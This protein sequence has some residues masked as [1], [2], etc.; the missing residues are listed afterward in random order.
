MSRRGGVERVDFRKPGPG[1]GEPPDADCVKPGGKGKVNDEPPAFRCATAESSSTAALAYISAWVCIGSGGASGSRF[2][3][4]GPYW[5]MNATT[6]R[7][8]PIRVYA[9]PRMASFCAFVYSV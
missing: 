6:S 9:N 7:S 2:T 5:C 8:L 1:V 3:S 4:M